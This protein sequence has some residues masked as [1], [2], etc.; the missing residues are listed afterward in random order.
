MGGMILVV[1]TDPMVVLARILMGQAGKFLI[2]MATSG[3][4][5]LILV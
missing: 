5:S 4:P 3:E 1:L 2:Q